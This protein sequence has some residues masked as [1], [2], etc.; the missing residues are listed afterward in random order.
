ML[1]YYKLVSYVQ[2]QVDAR[3]AEA[4]SGTAHLDVS[5]LTPPRREFHPKKMGKKKKKTL[6]A[7]GK[8]GETQATKTIKNQDAGWRF[9]PD[10]K[11]SSRHFFQCLGLSPTF[12]ARC[13]VSR[14]H[15]SVP[16]RSFF[17]KCRSLLPIKKMY[18]NEF[19]QKETSNS[20]D[21]IH[22]W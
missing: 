3:L 19:P 7:P 13:S 10:L 20:N 14:S 21:I 1:S 12:N 16:H 6:M 2:W 18:T 17:S 4:D 8:H 11:R 9:S 15:N 5:T 22:D